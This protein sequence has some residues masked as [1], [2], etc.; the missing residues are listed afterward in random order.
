MNKT[1]LQQRTWELGA[2][3]SLILLAA[4]T[5]CNQFEQNRAAPTD[6]SQ[7]TT[8]PIPVVTVE[9]RLVR[10]TLELPVTLVGYEQAGLMSKIDGY[11]KEVHVDIG[12]EVEQGDLL[13]TIES[14]EL[15]QNVD[16]QT[17]MLAEAMADIEL[18]AAKSE[19]AKAQLAKQQA[20]ID[21]RASELNRVERLVASGALN[22]QK[23]EEALFA[24][25][26]AE[27]EMSQS[28]SAVGVAAARQKMAEAHSEVV[29]A[30]LEQAQTM[31]DYQTIEAPFA[32][33]I[34]KRLVDP[35]DFVQPAMGTGAMPLVEIA[36][37]DKL[38]AIVHVT[39][40]KAGQIAVGQPVSVVAIDA[41]GQTLEGQVSR[42]SGI[43]DKDS[44]MMRAEIDI[45]NR[46]DAATGRRALR[47]GSYGTATIVLHEQTL[48][49]VPKTA[50]VEVGDK[51]TVMVV[52]SDG[53]CLMTAVVVSIDGGQLLGI[54]SGLSTG[55]RVVAHDAAA[56]QN[57]QT[58]PAGQIQSETY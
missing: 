10:E 34:T 51:K 31:A 32:G 12:D 44:R 58:V 38:R 17:K 49:A 47:A 18:A 1:A 55:D 45:D 25:S 13:V 54:A 20:M 16:Q 48:P 37:I 2:A 36:V 23:R 24:M 19:A 4:F 52:S 57:G 9:S 40:E 39:M 27:A 11:V 22:D 7:A 28:I 26:S 3:A 42:T 14:P 15:A 35:G 8:K 50:I 41:P 46:A 30:K 56:V 43:F 21:L 29:A 33:V 6:D 53:T 5:G